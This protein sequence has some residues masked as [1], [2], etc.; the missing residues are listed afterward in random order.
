MRKL[1]CGL[2]D[3]RIDEVGEIFDNPDTLS[4]LASIDIDD[5]S[6]I[7]KPILSQ[8]GIKT[9]MIKTFVKAKLCKK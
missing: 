3:A 2:S 4:L 9:K 6:G 1:F 5:P 7:V 8:K